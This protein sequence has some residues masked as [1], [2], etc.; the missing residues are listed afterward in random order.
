MS[1]HLKALG[2]V[3][4]ALVIMVGGYTVWKQR[5]V[6]EQPRPVSARAVESLPSFQISNLEGGVIQSHQLLGKVLVVNFWASWCAPCIEEIPSLI[7]L[8]KVMG[9]QVEILAISNDQVKEDIDVFLKSFPEF[10]SPLV[11]LAHDVPKELP[12]TKAFGVFRL[13]ESFVF[14]KSGRMVRKVIGTIDWSSSDAQEYLRSLV[15]E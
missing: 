15:N 2:A 8:K 12:V 6:S 10:R 9:E 5:A 4:M 1:A 11:L 3:L 13:P 14:N 7:R